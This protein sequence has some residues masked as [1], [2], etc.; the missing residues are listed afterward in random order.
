M[1]SPAARAH[2]DRL[3]ANL[4]VNTGN[5]TIDAD[6]HATNLI[7]HPRPPSPSYYHG[8][9]LSLEELAA[10]MDS[11]GVDLAN[12]W[13]NPAATIYPGDADSNTDALLAANRYLAAPGPRFIPSG[14]TDPRAC[15]VDGAIRIAEACVEDF[16]F[17][18]VKM[19]PGQ[20]RYPID[21]PAVLRVVDRIVELGATP[22]FHYG[23]DTPF[24]PAAGLEAIARRLGDCPILAVHMGGGGASYLEAEEQ[25]HQS[26][27]LGLRYP[28]IYYVFSA[29]RDTY[30]EAAIQAY[31][32]APG[33]RWRNLFAA[34]DA[35]YGRMSWNFGGFRQMLAA[36]PRRQDY[37][38]ANFARFVLAAYE[39]LAAKNF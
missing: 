24:T 12:V 13:Q 18:I 39:R 35:P 5:L 15:G 21:S 31:E 8:R 4:R 20:N 36:N 14:W 30:I 38:G 19:N 16:G 29:L 27:A 25:Y 26:I 11:A 17:A 34:S 6:T 9:P 37:L 33:E 28:N 3:T 7:D 1:L 22:A 23:A 10:E 2:I 32:A